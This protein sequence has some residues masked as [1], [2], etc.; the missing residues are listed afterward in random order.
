MARIE[1]CVANMRGWIAAYEVAREQMESADGDA[2]L[3]DTKRAVHEA[4]ALMQRRMVHG[5]RPGPRTLERALQRARQAPE[6]RSTGEYEQPVG[7]TEHDLSELL[8][9]KRRPADLLQPYA[10]AARVA[11][12]L[13]TDPRNIRRRQSYRYRMPAAPSIK[14]QSAFEQ[15]LTEIGDENSQELW[16]TNRDEDVAVAGI[17]SMAFTFGPRGTAGRKSPEPERSITPVVSAVA[18]AAHKRRITPD[19]SAVESAPN[20]WFTQAG[21]RTAA[22]TTATAAAPKQR[23][24]SYPIFDYSARHQNMPHTTLLPYPRDFEDSSSTEDS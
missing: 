10:V 9:W 23:P 20:P 11:R 22:Q 8:V 18:P 12:S 14:E 3:S 13:K 2:A 17:D 1:E 15:Y 24:A 6:N 5:V 19:V 21:K 4:E 16:R 7:S